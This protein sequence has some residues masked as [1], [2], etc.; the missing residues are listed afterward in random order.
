MALK[1]DWPDGAKV[2][3]LNVRFQTSMDG[4]WVD[5][6]QSWDGKAPEAASLG[7]FDRE[8]PVSYRVDAELTDGAT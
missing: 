7:P 6:P 8:T 5:V 1:L 3:S 2:R 4:P